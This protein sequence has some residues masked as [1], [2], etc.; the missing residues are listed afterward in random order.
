[1][2]GEGERWNALGVEV[3][4]ADD[5]DALASRLEAAESELA[6]LHETLADARHAHRS[7]ERDLA[8]AESALT[9]ALDAMEKVRDELTNGAT[10][11][12]KWV[13]RQFEI[14]ARIRSQIEGSK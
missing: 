7:A 13:E 8:S 5:Y 3:V 10:T 14:A 4:K 2:P 1:M 9:E 12:W 11:N 6:D